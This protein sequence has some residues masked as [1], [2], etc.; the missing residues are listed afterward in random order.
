MRCG[1]RMLMSRSVPALV[2]HLRW[3]EP[4]CVGGWGC[5]V[6]GLRAT[7]RPPESAVARLH[8]HQVR[9][10]LRSKLRSK[11]SSHASP[12]QNRCAASSSTSTHPSSAQ[13]TTRS[14]LYLHD[15]RLILSLNGCRIEGRKEEKKCGGIRLGR[16]PLRPP[17]ACRAA[18]ARGD[19]K[20]SESSSSLL[21]SALLLSQLVVPSGLISTSGAGEEA[22]IGRGRVTGN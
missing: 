21:A 13:A 15:A 10:K 6:R 3:V 4:G 8:R 11:L 19:A 1:G 18:A 2:S 7:C 20:S 9:T 22:A 14:T 17:R 5:A 16:P 12:H